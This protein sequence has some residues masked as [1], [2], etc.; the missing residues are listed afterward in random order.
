M[1]R[2][3]ALSLR[4]GFRC[5]YKTSRRSRRAL[6]GCRPIG[7]AR[8]AMSIEASK[9]ICVL[10]LCYWGASPKGAWC[11]DMSAAPTDGEWILLTMLLSISSARDIELGRWPTM[12]IYD[13]IPEDPRATP[14]PIAPRWCRHDHVALHREVVAWLRIPSLSDMRDPTKH[15][16]PS[17]R[18]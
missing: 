1:V 10:F 15:V 13:R 8:S 2:I 16:R 5:H 7:R 12:P 17:I 3:G 14:A 6:S 9:P 4:V 18:S 11:Y